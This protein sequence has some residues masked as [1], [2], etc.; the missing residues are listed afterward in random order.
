MQ[1]L[2]KTTIAGRLAKSSITIECPYGKKWKAWIINGNCSLICYQGWVMVEPIPLSDV[3][4]TVQTVP[5]QTNLHD[6]F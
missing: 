3:R 5:I 4:N 6:L 1:R 2:G